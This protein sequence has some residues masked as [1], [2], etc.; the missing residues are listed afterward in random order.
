MAESYLET[1][2]VSINLVKDAKPDDDGEELINALLFPTMQLKG[3]GGMFHYDLVS[4]ISDRIVQFLEVIARPDESIIEI[5]MAFHNTI[6][7]IVR[8]KMSGHGGK[9]GGALYKELDGACVRYF[10]AYPKNCEVD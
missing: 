9:Q 1:L 8:A 4:S 2:M 7:A 6:R 3:N 5:M 10:K